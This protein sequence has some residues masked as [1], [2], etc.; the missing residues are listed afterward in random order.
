MVEIYKCKFCNKEFK[1]GQS[2]GGHI[3]NCK[4]NPNNHQKEFIRR[5]SE[6][7]R[8]NNPIE[9]HEI[10]CPICNKKFV[11]KTSRKNF[12]NNKYPHTCSKTCACKLS[13][14]KSNLC[15]KNEKI[16]KAL[17]GKNLKTKMPCEKVCE[18]C[19]K[20]FIQKQ[21][22]EKKLS[23]SRFCSK[24]CMRKYLSITNKNNGSGGLR[25]N[26]YKKYKSGMYQGIH[27]DSSWELA[28]LI[29]CKDHDINIKRCKK[30]L[31]YLYEN[32]IFKYYPDFEVDGLMYEIK[33]YE[34]EKAKEKHKQHP[35][36]VYLDKEKMQK[37][38]KYVIEKYGRNFVNQYDRIDKR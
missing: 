18:V 23:I 29:Y 13:N 37:Y 6:K 2:L 20:V 36:V 24:E 32:K 21:I 9:E 25:E 14:Q 3:I 30:S 19:G 5:R 26:A 35:E 10:I 38:L 12:N 34:N 8:I 4:S 16:S 17:K 7:A 1:S 15:E 11:I 27:C 22:S 33:G 28:F 31:Q